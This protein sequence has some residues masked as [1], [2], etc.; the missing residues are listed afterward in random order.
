MAWHDG[1]RGGAAAG[2]ANLCTRP[3]LWEGGAKGAHKKLNILS[4]DECKY[5]LIVVLTVVVTVVYGCNRPDSYVVLNFNYDDVG[6]DCHDDF[7]RCVEDVPTIG[8]TTRRSTTTTMDA[9]TA[10]I[11]C[12]DNYI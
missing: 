1:S 6:N 2:T 11:T 7:N 8:A 12:N 4:L 9:T 10:K 3:P 5:C